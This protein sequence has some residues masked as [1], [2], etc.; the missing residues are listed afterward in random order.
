VCLWSGFV[1]QSD[2]VDLLDW[3]ALNYGDGSPETNHVLPAHPQM[4]ANA[5]LPAVPVI[6]D[7]VFDRLSQH[8]S[9]ESDSEVDEPI[10]RETPLPLR[11]AAVVK[12]VAQPATIPAL[13][14][15]VLAE[16]H[17]EDEWQGI[18]DVSQHVEA[19]DA[20][21]L[22]GVHEGFAPPDAVVDVSGGAMLSQVMPSPSQEG[23]PIELGG[24]DVDASVGDGVSRGTPFLPELEAVVFGS[25]SR[26]RMI[27]KTRRRPVV[28]SSPG[29]VWVSTQT[30]GGA[31]YASQVFDDSEEG[32]AG[33]EHRIVEERTLHSAF[34]VDQHGDTNED[35]LPQTVDDYIVPPMPSIRR[36]SRRASKAEIA[37][38]IEVVQGHHDHFEVECSPSGPEGGA[39]ARFVLFP[40]A[41]LNRDSL[42]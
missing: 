16:K 2:D 7:A 35:V 29:H 5:L 31:V 25:G 11:A 33:P 23:G 38:E 17:A 30:L 26:E 13:S 9:S 6:Q 39:L 18:R 22:V 24:V 14:H 10:V 1:K 3:M 20:G 32:V 8:S 34:N 19:E 21:R 42:Q 41:H 40:L 36:V 15:P 37:P 4:E 12:S 28:S 27:Q